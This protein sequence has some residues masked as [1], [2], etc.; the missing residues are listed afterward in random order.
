MASG[1]FCSGNKAAAQQAAGE[2]CEKKE[3]LSPVVRP[4]H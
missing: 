4:N 2:N 3:L 1:K